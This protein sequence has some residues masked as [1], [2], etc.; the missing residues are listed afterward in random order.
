MA[1]YREDEAQPGRVPSPHT[2]ATSVAAG[3][4]ACR[5]AHAGR[6]AQPSRPARGRRTAPRRFAPPLRR[7]AVAGPAPPLAPGPH[8]RRGAGS[9]ASSAVCYLRPARY[10]AFA[11]VKIEAER[12]ELLPR[13][14]VVSDLEMYRMTQISLMKSPKVLEAALLQDKVRRV[15]PPR[16]GRS[17]RLARG[18]PR[19]RAD[20]QYGPAAHRPQRS[21]RRRGRPSRQRHRAGLPPR[22]GEP[23]AKYRV[24][25]LKD[26]KEVCE[27]S[28][29]RSASGAKSLQGVAESL[30]ANDHQTTS[31]RHKIAL[32][33]YIALRK[34]L[35]VLGS[36]SPGLPGPRHRDA[37]GVRRRNGP[38][39]SPSSRRSTPTRTLWS[40][41]RR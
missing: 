19:R 2:T 22:G 35:I 10:T 1:P 14:R 11:F 16:G 20:P 37:R 17:C 39:G 32:E 5:Q 21:Q 9:A 27:K 29:E 38:G 15:V 36:A 25:R 18:R 3:R 24:T 7:L 30:K 26:L 12:P 34:E 41:P 40:R 4:L 23:G 8:R 28:E 31:F 13:D 33:E 6:A